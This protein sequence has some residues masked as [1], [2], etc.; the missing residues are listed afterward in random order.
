MNE[1]QT[2]QALQ[3]A[4]SST[5]TT[6]SMEDAFLTQQFHH[7]LP[8]ASQALILENIGFKRKKKQIL[9]D[10][11]CTIPSGQLTMIIGG[12]GGGKSS[13]LDII[14]KRVRKGCS[15]TI[16]FKGQPLTKKLF[17][18]QGGYV[19]Q[20]DILLST[21]TIHEILLES[22]LLKYK[23]KEGNKLSDI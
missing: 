15:G 5:S 4:E 17:H 11:S 16:T 21:D 19:Y 7:E 22:S 3:I 6:L 12:S 14:S 18:K 1:F 9:S 20:D 23:H 2:Q 13:L 8:N 10:I